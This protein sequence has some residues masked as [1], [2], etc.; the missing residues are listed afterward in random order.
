MRNRLRGRVGVAQLASVAVVGVGL[1]LIL[2][3]MF[4]SVVDTVRHEALCTCNDKL[5]IDMLGWLQLLQHRAGYPVQD[6]QLPGSEPS[7]PGK[8]QCITTCIQQPLL[9]ESAMHVAEAAGAVTDDFGVQASDKDLTKSNST[10]NGAFPRSGSTI[11]TLCTSNGS[12]YLNYQ[13]RIM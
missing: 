2:G 8:Q 6:R 7:M 9:L 13:T 3:F 10:T 5:S 11:H 12:P 4:M 1:G